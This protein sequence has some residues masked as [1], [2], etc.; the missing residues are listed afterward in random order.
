[1]QHQ[2]EKPQPLVLAITHTTSFISTKI[3][4]S[5]IKGGVRGNHFVNSESD[6]SPKVNI[7]DLF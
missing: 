5:F 3:H 1:M 4:I 6:S 2:E 7:F